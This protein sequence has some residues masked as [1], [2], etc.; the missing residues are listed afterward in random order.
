MRWLISFIRRWFRTENQ[1][2]GQTIKQLM[3]Y[4]SN[5]NYGNGYPYRS[6]A[7]VVAPE[8]QV[9]VAVPAQYD[10]TTILKSVFQKIGGRIADEQTK[11]IREGLDNAHLKHYFERTVLY[12]M[13]LND[14]RAAWISYSDVDIPQE[15]LR[16]FFLVFQNACKQMDIAVT[17]NTEHSWICADV[18]QVKKFKAFIPDQSLDIEGMTKMMLG[19]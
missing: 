1:N 10:N 6:A 16:P 12:L 7:V 14:G 8:E 3:H 18:A 2:T 19:K 15:L 17:W 11:Y 13:K 5:E 4:T 9:Y